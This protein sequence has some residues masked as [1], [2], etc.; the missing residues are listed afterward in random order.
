MVSIELLGNDVAG[1]VAGHFSFWDPGVDSSVRPPGFEAY[2]QYVAGMSLFFVDHERALQHFGRAMEL[3]PDFALPAL[4]S[5]SMLRGAGRITEALA[6]LKDIQGQRQSLNPFE[7]NM[8]EYHIAKLQGDHQRAILSIRRCLE[9]A[10]RSSYLRLTLAMNLLHSGRPRAALEEISAMANPGLWSGSGACRMPFWVAAEA[11]HVLGLYDGELETARQAMEACGNGVE[12]QGFRARAFIG[13]GE[14][15][16]LEEALG[17]G[18]NAPDARHLSLSLFLGI[19]RELDAHGHP[20]EARNIAERAVAYAEER[21]VLGSESKWHRLR[22]VVLLAML[23]RLHEAQ[24][25]LLT[26]AEE[27]PDDDDVLGWLGIVSAR[28][29]DMEGVEGYSKELM[30]L[31]RPGLFGSDH[32]Y[33]AAILAHSGRIDESLGV[34]RDAFARGHPWGDGLHSCSELKP[35]RGHPEFEAILHPEE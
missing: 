30:G 35:L 24:E 18:L 20:E 23:D 26:L 19:A 34:L 10:P 21:N 29:G 4:M 16:P 1:A 33:R 3:E 22:Y 7:R 12:F 28:L 25:A 9:L 6:I 11:Q 27:L 15:A 31:D 8:L 5:L 13:K 14:L 17:E 32:Y 2:Q